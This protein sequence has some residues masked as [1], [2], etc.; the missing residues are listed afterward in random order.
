MSLTKLIPAGDGTIAN[1]FY[2]VEFSYKTFPTFARL[3]LNLLLVDSSV[4]SSAGQVGGAD[5]GREG[6][7]G[8]G[9]GVAGPQGGIHRCQAG[10]H[11]SITGPNGSVADPGCLSRIPDPDFYPYRVRDPP[12]R[13]LGSR[14][15]SRILDPVSKNSNKTETENHSIFEMLNKRFGPIFKEI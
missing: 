7:A 8:C 5:E 15:G 1:L 12:I 2:S 14:P 13:D 10:Q 4:F 11:H 6:V 9:A 3:S